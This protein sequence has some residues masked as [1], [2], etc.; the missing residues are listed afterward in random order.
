MI[1]A[2]SPK[3]SNR[4]GILDKRIGGLTKLPEAS[5]PPAISYAEVGCMLELCRQLRLICDETRKPASVFCGKDATDT[6]S[7]IDNNLVCLDFHSK[8]R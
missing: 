7:E 1:T 8:S 4:R 3:R 2:V 6:L 5:G